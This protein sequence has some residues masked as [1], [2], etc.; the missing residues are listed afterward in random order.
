MTLR[1]DRLE[2]LSP[3]VWILEH[4]L[5]QAHTLVVGNNSKNINIENPEKNHTNPQIQ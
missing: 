5:P 3:K 1:I 4:F 2:Q